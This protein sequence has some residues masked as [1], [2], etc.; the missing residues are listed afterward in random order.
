MHHAGHIL[1]VEDDADQMQLFT[2][3]LA[4]A[5]YRYVTADDAETALILLADTR[6]DLLLTDLMLPGIHGD[7]LI[8]AVQDRFP[9]TKTI[10]MSNRYNAREIAEACGAD[11]FLPKGDLRRLVALV[12][13]GAAWR[14]R[15]IRVNPRSYASTPRPS[16]APAAWP[17]RTA[18]RRIPCGTP[19]AV[20]EPCARR[21]RAVSAPGPCRWH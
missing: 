18:S 20:G 17:G 19:T 7:A 9:E 3:A 6:F 5:G 12:G 8:N 13:M 4:T 21:G 15:E 14:H 1:I 2:M 11:A 16:P 10:L